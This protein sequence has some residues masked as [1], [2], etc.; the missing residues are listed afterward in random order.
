MTGSGGQGVTD[1]RNNEKY[2]LA[3]EI[4]ETVRNIVDSYYENSIE[5]E[6]KPRSIR[7]YDYDTLKAVS[8]DRI[9]TSP[10][11][12]ISDP[13]AVRAIRICDETNRP[14]EA[15]RLVNAVDNG[16]RKAAGTCAH[17]AKQE[18]LRVHL[19]EFMIMK[20][21][22]EDISSK[23]DTLIVYRQRAYYFIAEELNLI[24]RGR[25][26]QESTI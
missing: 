21:K 9:L 2:A 14:D 17:I 1:M 19:E 7:E 3:P 25:N 23:Y 5:M 13:T 6:K 15:R 20:K 10:T 26:D 8:Y 16:I 18:S 4:K 12:S 11:N 22:A 24:S